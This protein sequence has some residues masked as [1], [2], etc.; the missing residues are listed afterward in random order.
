MNI[1]KTIPISPTIARRSAYIAVVLGVVGLLW[2]ALVAQ[3]AAGSTFATGQGQG[4]LELTISS[5][6]IYNGVAQP[7]LSWGLKNL[8]PG[9]DRFFDFDDVKPGDLG[10]HMIGVRVEKNAAYACL[11]FTNLKDYE[12]GRIDSELLAGDTTEGEGEL[13]Q[14]TYVFA[15]RDEVGDGNFDPAADEPLFGNTPETA[16]VA[17]NNT[18]YP[19]ADASTG[20]VYDKDSTNYVGFAWCAG[21]MTVDF[22]SGLTACAGAEVGNITQTDSMELDVS[23]R[24]V[25]A[26]GRP[27]FYCRVQDVPLNPG[28][29]PAGYNKIVDGYDDGLS[30]TSDGNYTGVVLAGGP[31]GENNQDPDGRS[32]YFYDVKAGDTIAREAHDIS[33]I[34]ATTDATLL[35]LAGTTEPESV[36][37]GQ[38]E[39][40]TPPVGPVEKAR[41]VG[42]GLLNRLGL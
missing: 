1:F 8:V 29:C 39:V 11:D 10:T 24:A 38:W 13:S 9:V 21:E 30:W 12:N 18:T 7:A 32:K 31:P 2:V 26:I 4:K 28:Q 6:A 5:S 36:V 42:R 34:C 17:L 23:I 22:D 19:L 3:G 20:T 40:V 37:S 15:W 41:G 27:G 35:P 33:Y 14:H 16:I 25:A